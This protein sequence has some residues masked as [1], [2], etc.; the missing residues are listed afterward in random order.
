MI[1]N[2]PPTPT[3]GAAIR[4]PANA[5]PSTRVR[6][7]FELFSAIAF[8]RSSGPTRS[9]TSAWRAGMLNAKQVPWTSATANRCQSRICPV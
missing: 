7:M 6:F 9:A 2:T 5:G 4:K 8:G 1:R 3:A